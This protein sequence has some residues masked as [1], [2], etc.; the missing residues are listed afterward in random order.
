MHIIIY[1]VL[2]LVGIVL[3]YYEN[4]KCNMYIITSII[5]V[6]IYR[7]SYKHQRL[8]TFLNT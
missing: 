2:Y 7:Y 6:G 8:F 3:K 5:I 4:N 1:D